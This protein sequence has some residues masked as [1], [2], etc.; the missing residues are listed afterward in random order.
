MYSAHGGILLPIEHKVHK[1]FSSLKYRSHERCFSSE[2]MRTTG[3]GVT[4]LHCELRYTSVVSNSA[5]LG[6]SGCFCAGICPGT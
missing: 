2:S 3:F 5:Q 1:I 6:H 4:T